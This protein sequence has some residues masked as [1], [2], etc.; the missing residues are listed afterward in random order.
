MYRE[1]RGLLEANGIEVIPFERHSDVLSGASAISL[2][3]SALEAAWSR[4][5]YQDVQ[6]LIRRTRPTVAHFHNTFPLISPSAYAACHSAGVPVVQTL[7][8]FR[9]VCPGAML[10]RDGR[11]CEECLGGSLLPALRHRC[12]RN[13]LPATATVVRSLYLNRRRDTYSTLVDRYIALTGFARDRLIAGGLPAA[14][15]DIKPNGLSHPPAP[16]TGQGGYVAFVGR[17]SEEKGIR[18]LLH[19]WR[20]LPDVQL[21]VV[22]DGPLRSELQDFA[23][24]EALNVTFV[25][26]QSREEVTHIVGA[27]AALVMPSLW[28]EGLP[29]VAIEAFASGTPVLASNIGSLGEI[30]TDGSTGCLFPPGDAAALAATLQQMLASPQ[31]LAAMR[32]AARV[33]FE[34]RYSPGASYRALLQIYRSVCGEPRQE[35]TSA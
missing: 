16:G 31:R 9:L 14:L 28:F 27:A 30:V 1:E 33:Q 2:A 34:R 4:R 25:G 20:Q 23:R 29:M 19:A 17:L 22:G 26:R 32:D 24:R 18:V 6:R 7:H 3:K 10:F 11:P 21:R 15:I 12:Y 13:S 8:N 35:V 5:T